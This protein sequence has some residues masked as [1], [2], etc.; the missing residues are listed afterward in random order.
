MFTASGLIGSLV[1]L[2]SSHADAL[3]FLEADL[4]FEN[5][6]EVRTILHDYIHKAINGEMPIADAMAAAQADA[7]AALEPFQQ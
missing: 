5:L 2:N 4:Y 7:A 6:G 1:H 3:Q